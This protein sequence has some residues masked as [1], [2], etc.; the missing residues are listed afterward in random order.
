MHI[1]C[2][3]ISILTLKTCRVCFLHITDY[4]SLEC[5]LILANKGMPIFFVNVVKYNA[6]DS[7]QLID[8]GLLKSR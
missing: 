1:L 8:T 7:Q 5:T 3:K 2:F 4:V 6:T